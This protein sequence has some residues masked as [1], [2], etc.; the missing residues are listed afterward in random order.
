M[1]KAAKSKQPKP[2]KPSLGGPSTMERIAK[3]GPKVMSVSERAR[4]GRNFPKGW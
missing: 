2:K 4:R 1:P 3:G